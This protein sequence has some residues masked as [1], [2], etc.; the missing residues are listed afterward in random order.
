MLRHAIAHDEFAE[1]SPEHCSGLFAAMRRESICCQ[2]RPCPEEDM[3]EVRGKYISPA[4]DQLAFTCPPCN[5]LAKQFW[6]SVHADPLKSDEKPVVATA[7]TVETLTFSNGNL[8]EA[9][10]DRELKW[11]EQMASGRPFLE[12]HREFRNR[13]VQNVSISYCFSCNEMCLWVYD[14]L[15][16]PRRAGAPELKPVAPSDVQ[17]EC[18][19]TSQKLEASPRGAAALLRLAMEKLCKELG[20]NGESL[21]EDLAFFLREDVDA[22]VRK[23]LDAARIIESNAVRPGQIGLGDDRATAETLAGLVN[24]ICEKMIM[25]P[26]HLQEVYTKLRDGAQTAMEQRAQGSS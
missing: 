11:A 23:V 19:E 25:E 1:A 7:E 14:Q 16:W 2:Q 24:L 12:V 22:R 26:R 6:F 4:I 13:D 5:A 8:E 9:E 18:E 21:N 17:R 10:R 20:V 3:E 15:V